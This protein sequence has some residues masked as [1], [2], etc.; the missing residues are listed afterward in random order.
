MATTK[1]KR[2]TYYE[3]ITKLGYSRRDFMKFATFMAAYMGLKTSAVGQIASSLEKTPR[4]PVIW[5]HFQEC[6]C[7][8]E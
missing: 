7:C 1:E 2:D 3:S 8:S 5:E 4:L 6:T